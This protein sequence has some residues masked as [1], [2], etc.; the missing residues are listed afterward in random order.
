M[1]HDPAPSLGP[2]LAMESPPADPALPGPGAASQTYWPGGGEETR[3]S[4]VEYHRGRQSGGL[5]PKSRPGLGETLSINELAT[6]RQVDTKNLDIKQ[7]LDSHEVPLFLPNS[8]PSHVHEGISDEPIRLGH[9]TQNKVV[10]GQLYYVETAAELT[11]EDRE[12]MRNG[13]WGDGPKA[14]HISQVDERR[15]QPASSQAAIERFERLCLDSDSIISHAATWGTEQRGLRNASNIVTTAGGNFL[16]RLSL[17]DNLIR[18]PSI[19]GTIRGLVKKQKHSHKRTISIKE[20]DEQHDMP[21]E[22]TVDISRRS[23]SPQPRT[24]TR[25]KQPIPSIN[26]ALVTGTNPGSSRRG[27]QRSGVTVRSSSS[28]TTLVP[29]PRSFTGSLKL[30]NALTQLRTKPDPAKGPASLT[31]MWKKFGGPPVPTLRKLDTPTQSGNGDGDSGN[32]EGQ[33]HGELGSPIDD[34]TPSFSGFQE[35]VLMLNPMLESLNPYLVD[36]ISH[37]MVDRYANLLSFRARHSNAVFNADCPC[38]KLCISQ[39]GPANLLDTKTGHDTVQ[40][41]LEDGDESESDVMGYVN[42]ESFPQGIPMPPTA[43]LPAE[44]ECQ[45]CFQSKTFQTP[46]EWILHVHEDVQPYF[47][48]WPS[49]PAPKM[50]KRKSDWAR[51]ENECHRHNEW[52]SCDIEH[53]RYFCYRRETFVQHLVREHKYAEPKFKTK[54]PLKRASDPTWR[55]AEMCHQ[56]TNKRPEEEPCCFCGKT[57]SH[58]KELTVHLA[59]HMEHISLP[60]LRLLARK[61][62]VADSIISP[63]QALPPPAAPPAILTTPASPS[64][65]AIEPPP[66]RLA[67][68]TSGLLPHT[69]PHITIDPPESVHSSNS[70]APPSAFPRSPADSNT[71]HH[72]SA[73]SI[74]STPVTFHSPMS[75]VDSTYG[76]IVKSEEGSGGY[77]FKFPLFENSSEWPSQVTHAS[78]DQD[79]PWETQKSLTDSNTITKEKQTASDDGKPS[80][81]PSALDASTQ[82]S[83][84]LTHF[85]FPTDF[86]EHPMSTGW[87]FAFPELGKPD[88]TGSP[89]PDSPSQSPSYGE[90]ATALVK[91]SAFKQVAL[92]KVRIQLLELSS[93][94]ANTA[95]EFDD[96]FESSIEDSYDDDESANDDDAGQAGEGCGGNANTPCHDT[97]GTSRPNN[98]ARPNF[99]QSRRAGRGG[100]DRQGNKRKRTRKESP[101]SQVLLNHRRFACPYQVYE[102]QHSCLRPGPRNPTGGCN[103]INRLKQVTLCPKLQATYPLT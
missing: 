82:T 9:E 48:T 19:F 7:W 31:E 21:V 60:I 55:K 63:V 20:E 70:L 96:D 52:Y 86:V 24:T 90:S 46:R 4:V 30:K 41:P 2:S 26:T 83:K 44:V 8:V 35:Y 64:P 88:R 5:S 57:F 102:P 75:S 18:R 85:A 23:L 101:S 54:A 91:G 62:L 10:S 15:N 72:T 73:A 16:R 95:S 29:S 37:H 99:A 103:G 65:S 58:W 22:P 71:T 81:Q 27:S 49:C 68:P 33:A 84:L 47:C 76:T 42:S 40:A 53:C 80:V 100:D 98:T 94:E 66:Q 93:L 14:F 32:V 34:I 17:D 38:G 92:A 79:Q 74:F 28:G 12:L 25:L 45:L 67:P 1:E 36:R 77:D 59:K 61:D 11:T 87:E 6:Q 51:H 43:K 69:H 56:W 13:Y 3:N 50:F 39:G 97:T 89:L 78:D